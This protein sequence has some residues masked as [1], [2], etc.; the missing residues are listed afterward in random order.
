MGAPDGFEGI[1]AEVISGLMFSAIGS[2]FV[3]AGI[4]PWYI[5]ALITGLGLA[6]LIKELPVASIIYLAGW[7]FGSIVFLKAG[8]LGPIDILFNLIFPIAIVAFRILIEL[9]GK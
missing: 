7:T 2:A 8:L 4:M 9:K 1:S 6:A 5:M 3:G